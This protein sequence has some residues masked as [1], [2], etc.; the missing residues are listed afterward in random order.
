MDVM[1]SWLIQKNSAA[2]CYEPRLLLK[3]GYF[4]ISCWAYGMGA[5][6][7]LLGFISAPAETK[8]NLNFHTEAAAGLLYFTRWMENLLGNFYCVLRV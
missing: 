7:P 8:S 6:A 2:L 5:S 4:W 1:H 3:Q